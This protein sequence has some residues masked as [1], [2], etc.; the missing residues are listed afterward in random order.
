MKEN[1]MATSKGVFSKE[2]NPNDRIF[3]DHKKIEQLVYHCRG[4]GLKIV[5]TQGTYDMVHIGHGRYLEEAKKRGDL[6][7]V[8]VDS[9]K[10]VKSRK[11]PDRPVVPQH[12]RL[13]MLTHLRTVDVVFLKELEHPK[14]ALIKAVRPDVLIATKQTYNKSQL[15]ELKKYCKEV[16]VLEPRATTSTSAK[17]RLLQ[18]GT[19]KKLGQAL[20]PRLIKTIEEVLGGVK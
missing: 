12:E 11:G 20:T 9:D 5:L 8:G 18:I 17:I 7:I 13:E 14:W 19:A 3:T 6:L 16:V 2:A 4:L 10:K 1:I 15:K